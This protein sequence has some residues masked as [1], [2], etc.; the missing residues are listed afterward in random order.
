MERVIHE[1]LQCGGGVGHAEEHDRR[2]EEA[3]MSDEGTFPLISVLDADIVVA[4]S[5]VE[6]G[7]D[8]SSFEFIDEV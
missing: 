3:F 6:F 1:S 4:P 2:F 8:L 5:N 7:E